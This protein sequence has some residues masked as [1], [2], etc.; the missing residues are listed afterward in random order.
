MTGEQ[1]RRYSAR[2]LF[3]ESGAYDLSNLKYIFMILLEGFF[4]VAIPQT[5]MDAVAEAL[6]HL[7]MLRGYY[8]AEMIWL[9]FTVSLLKSESPFAV[10]S[11]SFY[12]DELIPSWHF[13]D[14]REDT[15]SLLNR[16]E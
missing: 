5:I 6:S 16:N 1:R 13:G 4:P 2:Q 7:S 10:G 14:A 15:S 9:S 12:N 8:A 3:G 11:Y